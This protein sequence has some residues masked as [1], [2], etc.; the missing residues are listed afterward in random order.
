MAKRALHPA[1]QARAA[2]VQAAHAHLARSVPGF[3]QLPG[4]AQ[5]RLTQQHVGRRKGPR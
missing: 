3:K 2:A 4:H 5:L 1:L